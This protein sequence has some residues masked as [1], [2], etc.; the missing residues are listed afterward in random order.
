MLLQVWRRVVSLALCRPAWAGILLAFGRLFV[1]SAAAAPSDYVINVWGPDSDLPSSTVT[2]VVQ[3]PDGYLW[4]GTYEGLARFDGVRFVTFDP[5]THPE[6]GHTRIQAL[7]L[8]AS[9]TLWI[10]TFRGG[11]TSYR[12]GVF[13]EE[14][15][16]QPIFDLRT[17]M[18]W[19]SP[20]QVVFM[21][22]MGQVLRRSLSDG[23]TNW[24]VVHPPRNTRPQ[25]AD[26]DGVIWYLSRDGRIM[27]LMN[28]K[29]EALADNGG[30][31]SN[32]V[33]T[34]M[35]D[36]EGRIWAGGHNELARWDGSHFEDLTPTNS[37]PGQSFDPSLIFPTSKGSVWV[38]A[39]ERFREEKNREWIAEATEWHGLLGWASG[40]AMGTHEDGAGGIWLNHYGNGVFH[41][42]ADGQFERF[43]MTNGLPSDRVGTW[44]QGRDGGMWMGA[45][46]GGLIRLHERH[47]QMVA[48]D[49]ARTALSLCEDH[50]GTVWIGTSG[51]GLC[52]WRDGKL[53][54]YPIGATASSNLVFSIF[55][56]KEGGLWLSA[57]DGEDLL[58]L[59]DGR[60]QRAPWDVHGVKSLLAD[61]SGRLWVGTKTNIGWYTLTGRR[62]SFGTNEGVGLSAV[63]AMT[64]APDG[65]IWC[66]A[67][68]GTLY[69]CETNQV[70]AYRPED[71]MLW[72]S[73]PIWSLLADSNGVIWAGTSRGGLLRFKDGKFT[74]LAAKQGLPMN[75]I[76]QL[77][78]DNQGRLWLGT[79]QGI[80][81]V[82]K[83]ALEACANGTKDAVDVVTY[84]NGSP[85][86]E[87]SDEYQPDCWRARDG[88]LWFATVN[89]VVSV[90]PEKVITSSLPPPVLMEEFRVDG[91]PVPFNEGKIV[92]PP[93]HK[94][95]DFQFTALTFNAPDRARF[96][97]RLDKF[98]NDWV[99]SDTKRTAHYG[100]LTP[101]TYRFQVIA[102]NSDGVW[103]KTGASLEF[104]V[105]PYFYQTKSFLAIMTVLVLGGVA[106]AVRSMATRKYRRE[107]ARLA[108]QHA[109]ERDRARIAKDIHDDIG[110]GLTQITLLSELARREPGHADAQLDRI[111]DSARDLT[112]AMDEIVWAVDPQHDTL[113]SLMDYIS[114]YAEDFLRTANIRCRID[115]PPTLPAMQVDAESRYNLFL[116]LKESLNNVV[117][118][119][120]ASEVWLR[121]RLYAKSFT[122]VV[123][124]NGRGLK[125]VNGETSSASAERFSSGSGLSNLK[126]R[127]EAVG[128][129]CVVQSSAG[130]GTRVEMMIS[131]NGAPSSATAIGAD[132][133][134]NSQEISSQLS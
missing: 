123:E 45:D 40:R 119:S 128:G 33:T 109:V 37:E 78:E 11:L 22:Q 108:Q 114:A 54:S 87:C 64:Q 101:N 49:P 6:L 91:E 127:L 12:D 77:L 71:E 122:L 70:L 79:H 90:D 58:Q 16:N 80:C 75:A 17:T 134:Q 105:R 1:G 83:A 92:V 118:H 124:D 96:R 126:K 132:Q 24:E 5:S 82:S 129:R 28:D 63:R 88:R 131:M 106:V 46:H 65:T 95:F 50:E 113:A 103:N 110:A 42:T 20:N 62:R 133:S 102:C 81:C 121:L 15:P 116:A 104:R 38:L 4:V 35:S 85:A 57:G 52:S 73:R 27:R 14:W 18:L 48:L 112:R 7:F 67:D 98:D 56:Q 125:G 97:Y 55:P 89:G 8:D 21:T 26:H 51:G 44:Y 47:F 74:R 68:D 130:A 13:R 84:L 30:F 39:N 115:L 93:G 66:G 32:R 19:S 69:R 2:S 99:E 100:R 41:V 86:L 3:T 111:S 59:R 10:N 76:S 107:L 117:K 72:G 36:T 60:I 23:S 43:T 120:G 53:T 61:D 94:Q 29:I 31:G 25:C 34:L 9:G